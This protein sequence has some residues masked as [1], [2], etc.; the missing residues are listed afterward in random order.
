MNKIIYK[1]FEIEHICNLRLKNSYISIKKDFKIVMKTPKV[2][3][4]FITKLLK[5]KEDWIRKQLL[6]FELN[7]PKKINLKD[8]VLLFG[9]IISIDREEASLLRDN[10]N[11]LKKTQEINIL[12]SYND[13][14]K[15][16]ANEY[17]PNRVESFAK[18]MQLKFREL[19]FKNL[20]SRWGSCSSQREITLNIQLIKVKKQL[21]DYVIV[22]ELAHL[23]HMNHSKEFHSLVN[24]YLPNSKTLREQLKKIQ[25]DF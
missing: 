14:Y 12:N 20:K 18:I 19:K 25:L 10:L 13:F 8:E 23:V 9:E 17:L 22:H 21:I 16:M 11:S 24:R 5:E 15:H 2:S 1:E 6:K 3:D 4:S 7:R